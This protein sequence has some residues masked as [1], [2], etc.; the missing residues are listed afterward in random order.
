MTKFAYVTVN[1]DGDIDSVAAFDKRAKN[2]FIGARYYEVISMEHD[3]MDSFIDDIRCYGIDIIG[4]D[5]AV[6]RAK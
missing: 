2:V 3:D 6:I 1:S 5:S 4:E